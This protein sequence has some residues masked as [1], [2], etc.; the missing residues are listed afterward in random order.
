MNQL[1]DKINA[2]AMRIALQIHNNERVHA[3][4]PP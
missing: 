1:M 2:L 4:L 3:Q